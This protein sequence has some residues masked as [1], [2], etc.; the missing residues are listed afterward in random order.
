MFAKHYAKYYELF[1]ADKPYKEE[2]EFVYKWAEKPRKILD[3]GCGTANYWKYYPKRVLLSGAESSRQMIEQSG[4]QDQIACYDV[5]HAVPCRWE[6]VNCVTAI[7]D[8]INYIPSQNWW[9]HLPLRPGGYFIFDIWDKEKVDK[10]GFEVTI[11]EAREG[12]VIRTITPLLYDGKQVELEIAVDDLGVTFK[13]VH[14]MY[15]WSH[16]D[17][18][19]FCGTDFEIV[20]KKATKSW[21]TWYKLKRK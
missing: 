19:K 3:V 7:F 1:N 12:D 2:I 21:Q 4:K 10:D 14:R 6:K 8:V 9:K 11:K 20:D 18:V 15:V 13:E 5:T 17:I 16:E